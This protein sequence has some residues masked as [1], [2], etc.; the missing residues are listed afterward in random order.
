MQE[1]Y[2]AKKSVKT[3]YMEEVFSKKFKVVRALI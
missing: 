1:T 3:T 2:V